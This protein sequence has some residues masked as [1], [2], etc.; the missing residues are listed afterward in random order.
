[1]SGDGFGGE[2]VAVDM[3]FGVFGLKM[4]IVGCVDVEMWLHLRD[5]GTHR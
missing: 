4:I 1:M 5:I 2:G 3:P